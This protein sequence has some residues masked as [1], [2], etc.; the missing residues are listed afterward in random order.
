MS[1]FLFCITLYRLNK[2]TGI[3]PLMYQE[4]IPVS[5]YCEIY[6]AKSVWAF[7]CRPCFNF[8]MQN[9]GNG[10]GFVASV[11]VSGYSSQSC[12]KTASVRNGILSR[13]AVAVWVVSLTGLFC[14]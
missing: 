2:S 6:F 14:P 1:Y 12:H 10:R 9:A 13:E 5:G 8:C 3:Y 7:A 4:N 11:A